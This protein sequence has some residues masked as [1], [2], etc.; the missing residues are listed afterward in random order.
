MLHDLCLGSRLKD[1]D[2]PFLIKNIEV[3]SST[4]RVGVR[5]QDG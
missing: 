4:F 3:D 2:T 5:G 1:Y